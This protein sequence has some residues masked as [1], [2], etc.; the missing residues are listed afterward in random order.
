MINI[1]RNIIVALALPIFTIPGL[2]HAGEDGYT[3]WDFKDPGKL[4]GWI[5]D[6]IRDSG[7]DDGA[8]VLLGEKKVQLRFPPGLAIN[9]EKDNYL[10]LRLRIYSPR[11]IQVF[12]AT[13][14][15][16]R[17]LPAIPFSPLLDQHFHTYWIDLSDSLEW[18]G[19]I[20]MMGLAF[21]G[22]PGRIDIDSIEIRPFSLTLYLS[23]Q[24]NEFWL[25]RVLH[26]GT[27]NSLT[28]PIIL[29]KSLITWLSYIVAL[30][31]IITL[32]YYFR[33]KGAQNRKS[34]LILGSGLLIIWIVYDLRETYSQFKMTEEIHKSYIK[35]P[36]DQKTYPALLDYYRFV[37]LCREHLPPDAQYHYYK[38]WPFDCR[39]RYSLYPRR[40]N[41]DTFSNII[42]GTPIPYHLVYQSP[43]VSYDPEGRQLLYRGS[44]ESYFISAPGRIIARMNPDTFI[45]K[46]N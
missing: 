16:G 28:S 3:A 39:I 43:E 19:K 21:F 20:D 22:Q 35:P 27:I 34:F 15:S 7:I 14:R 4:Q 12:W 46:E 5:G 30:I 17:Q 1:F 37:D 38:I 31:F 6:G 9:S 33:E 32:L 41:H 18:I 13:Q 29:N 25:P 23:D 2:V 42:A 11:L 44:G 10:R 8:F 36:P 26:L 40:G 45:F 24:W